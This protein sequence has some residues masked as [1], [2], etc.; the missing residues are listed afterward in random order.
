MY[1]AGTLQ[2]HGRKTEGK[3]SFSYSSRDIKVSKFTVSSVSTF[4]AEIYAPKSQYK[5]LVYISMSP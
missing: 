2:P 4:H 5:T 3:K 1:Q